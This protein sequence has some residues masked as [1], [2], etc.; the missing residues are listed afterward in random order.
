[1]PELTHSRLGERPALSR[2]ELFAQHPLLTRE[3]VETAEMVAVYR[4][5]RFLLSIGGEGCCI[6]GARLSGKSTL[7]ST[8]RLYLGADYPDVPNY[9]FVMPKAE[10]TRDEFH[11][12][13][14]GA[15]K[16]Q[17]FQGSKDTRLERIRARFVDDA[18]RVGARK[19]ALFLDNAHLMKQ[20]ELDFLTDLQGDLA[21]DNLH[22]VCILF[23]DV[24]TA[25]GLLDLG[26]DKS[27]DSGADK[28]PAINSLNLS[29]LLR[30]LT[31]NEV[32]LVFETLDALPFFQ[33]GTMWTEFFV[34]QAWMDGWRLKDYVGAF[35]E[36]LTN[37][38]LADA[39]RAGTAKTKMDDPDVPAGLLFMTLRH[40]MVYL[41]SLGGEFDKMKMSEYWE[42]AIRVSGYTSIDLSLSEALPMF[43]FSP[44]R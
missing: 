10:L 37:S 29:V 5:I 6:Q 26:A 38:G 31:R 41:G 7:I 35:F 42:T 21:V 33:A 15:L 19:I 24:G 2:R 25:R 43:G 40:L 30:G 27:Q 44:T 1:V 3:P 16:H 4:L 23:G 12:R 32:R 28:S 20:R 34:P 14:L 17:F 11:V 18:G 8:V 36:G 39:L 9:L 22:L 13:W